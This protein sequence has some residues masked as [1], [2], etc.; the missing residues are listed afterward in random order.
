MFHA[1]VWVNLGGDRNLYAEYATVWHHV[2]RERYPLNQPPRAWA[3]SVDLLKTPDFALTG[4][5]SHVDA[6]Y[7]IIYSSIHP[8]FELIEGRPANPVRLPHREG[9]Q[10]VVGVAVRGG[11]LRLAV[12]SDCPQRRWPT[13]PTSR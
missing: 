8:Y 11:G 2:N 1:D 9:Q 7:D 5:H 13:G 10:L 4:Y 3:V 12:G 6:E